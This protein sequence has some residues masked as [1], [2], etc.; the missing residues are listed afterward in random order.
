MVSETLQPHP[1]LLPQPPSPLVTV[2]FI[3]V[4]PL[5]KSSTR[6]RAFARALPATWNG[7]LPHPF[8]C[9]VLPHPL[10]FP[11]NHHLFR[12]ALSCPLAKQGPQCHKLLRLPVLSL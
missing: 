6:H 3:L 8:A 4:F 12:D 5:T 1:C 10:D 9:L 2:V 11:L 7:L